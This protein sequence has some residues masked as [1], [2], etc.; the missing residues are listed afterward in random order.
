MSSDL[1]QR[2]EQDGMVLLDYSALARDQIDST[3]LQV[4]SQLGQAHLHDLHGTVIWDVRNQPDGV[5]RSHGAGEFPLHTDCSFEEPP[6]RYV[7]L[8]VVEADQLGGGDT[9]WVRSRDVVARLSPLALQALAEPFRMRVPDEFFKGQT[10][11]EGALFAPPDFFRY[12]AECVLPPSDNAQRL[13]LVE[14]DEAL[15]SCPV[16]KQALPAGS[17]LLLDNWRHFHG[18]EAVRDSRRHLKRVRFFGEPL[19]Q[20][21]G[22][23][24]RHQ[25]AWEDRI[26]AD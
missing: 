23:E 14:L 16:E 2:L 9:Y 6:P 25:R 22:Q 3:I 10:M 20:V 19:P 11:S 12:R 26:D 13:A 24:C 15:R 1:R 5:A 17:F 18:R 8:F 7:G 21:F 4:I